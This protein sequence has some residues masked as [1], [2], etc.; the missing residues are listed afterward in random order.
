MW[1]RFDPASRERMAPRLRAFAPDPALSDRDRF[2]RLCEARPDVAAQFQP[3]PVI[4]VQESG[5]W[6]RVRLDRP[7]PMDRSPLP[8]P[9]SDVTLACHGGRWRLCYGAEPPEK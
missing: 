3:G 9:T 4:D 6:A 8:E 7:D 2:A 5:D 1:D